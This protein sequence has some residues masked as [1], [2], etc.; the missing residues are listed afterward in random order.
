[1]LSARLCGKCVTQSLCP[2]HY[3]NPVVR[4]ENGTEGFNVV[5]APGSRLSSSVW[6]NPDSGFGELD[7]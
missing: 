4:D 2:R 1:M 7:S 3:F 5:T 6:P